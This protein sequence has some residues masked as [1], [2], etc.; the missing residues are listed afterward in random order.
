MKIQEELIRLEKLAQLRDEIRLRIH[1]A[2]AEMRDHW[3][4]LEV[5]WTLLQ[6]R[7]NP[8]K[9]AGAESVQGLGEAGR[10]LLEELVEG[11]ERIRQALRDL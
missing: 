2:G 9:R 3:H 10:L 11:Y 6:T 8:V 7:L 1:L 4:Q 5:K